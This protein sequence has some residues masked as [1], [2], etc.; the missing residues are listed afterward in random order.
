MFSHTIFNLLKEFSRKEILQLEYFL[1]STYHNKSKKIILLFKEIKK[2]YPD[3][4]SVKLTKEGLSLKV[5][6]GLKFKESTLRDLMSGLLR[7]I[8]E[9]LIFEEM[10]RNHTDKLFLLLKSY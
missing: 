10:N 4:K 3:F 6:P 1:K 5:N 2:Y 8:E 7:C 9:F